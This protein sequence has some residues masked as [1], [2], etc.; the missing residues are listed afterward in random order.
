ML[1]KTTTVPSDVPSPQPRSSPTLDETIMVTMSSDVPL[2]LSGP[3]LPISSPPF[4]DPDQ[5]HHNQDFDNE[6]ECHFHHLDCIS[7]SWVFPEEEENNLG[8][9]NLSFPAFTCAISVVCMSPDLTYPQIQI[10]QL[11]HH[12]QP[13]TF[14]KTW[15]IP[16][17]WSKGL[18]WIV[19]RQSCRRAEKIREERHTQLQEGADYQDSRDT[20][21]IP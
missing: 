3:Q 2:D 20:T 14:R 8:A 5:V 15:L 13:P 4:K 9:E 1:D 16:M 19:P 12:P 18:L 11:H 17:W 21:K 7:W 10:R 6:G